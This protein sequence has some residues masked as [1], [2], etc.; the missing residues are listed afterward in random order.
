MRAAEDVGPYRLF[1]FPFVRDD[2]SNRSRSACG[3]ATGGID[4][5]S[6]LHTGK[7]SRCVKARAFAI[8]RDMIPGSTIALLYALSLPARSISTIAAPG[9][10]T[11][12]TVTIRMRWKRTG[13]EFNS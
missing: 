11:K 3:N 12:A 2:E 4:P 7:I 13:E 5:D 6:R 1:D 9:E 8:M 10:G